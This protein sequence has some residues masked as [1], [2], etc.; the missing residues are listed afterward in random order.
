MSEPAAT[1][2][3]VFARHPRT[4]AA[5]TVGLA[6]LSLA[7][8]W[9][10]LPAFLV[11]AICT[12]ALR[13]RVRLV[14]A[15]GLAVALAGFARFVVR[16][17]APAIVLA[18]QRSAEE[19]AVSRLREILWAEDQ[20]RELKVVPN[21]AGEG[22]YLFLGELLGH[23]R[24]R[25]GANDMPLLRQDSYVPVSP[26]ASARGVFRA[27]SYLF[28]VYLPSTGGAAR[29]GEQPDGTAA[30]RAF[31]AYAWPLG[32]KVSGSR[33]FFLDERERICEAD[34]PSGLGGPG[35]APEPFA[36]FAARSFDAARCAEGVDGLAWR[37]WRH[38]EPRP[39]PS[40]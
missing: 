34:V 20:A 38:K 15:A 27:D 32:S 1:T 40:P 12:I 36:A 16:D 39:A 19:K 18:G 25:R 28:T 23:D 9:V 37:A 17:A 35:R 4:L 14:A 7:V 31:V 13:G 30:A 3:D 6:T 10:A 33:V 8:A 29:E 21:A 26:E 24:T 11:G 5:L 22:Q 2:D